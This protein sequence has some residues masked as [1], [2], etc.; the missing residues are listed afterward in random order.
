MTLE[1]LRPV[2]ERTGYPVTYQAWREGTA[3]AMPYICYLV[4]DY[5][6][7]H[8]DACVYYSSGTVQVVL[9]TANKDL[10]AEGKV[11]AALAD[12]H[13]QKT[14]NYLEQEKCYQIIYEI[15]V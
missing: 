2:L 8:A 12:F 6:E 15:E 1:E 9:Y 3:P 14:E 13:W 11:E 5:Y 10:T 4:V 7:L